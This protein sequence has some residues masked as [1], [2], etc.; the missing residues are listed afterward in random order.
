MD[1]EE[2]SFIPVPNPNNIQNIGD[3]ETTLSLKNPV[4]KYPITDNK[5]AH[6]NIRVLL[7]FSLFSFITLIPYHIK[8][9]NKQISEITPVPRAI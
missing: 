7:P 1:V 8:N 2:D 6:D 3:T 5:I 9:I 4:T